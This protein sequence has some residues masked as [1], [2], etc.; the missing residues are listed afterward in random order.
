MLVVV[1]L[2]TGC[3]S[4][5]GAIPVN[6]PADPAV[7]H[8]A[9][10]V[11]RGTVAADHRYFSGIPYA[12][13]PIGQLRF[14]SP[15]PVAAWTGLRDATRPGSRCIQDASN[16]VDRRRTSEDCLTLNVWT[17]PPS[18]EPRPVMVWI[19]GGGFFNG[20]G[21]TYDAR[22]LA[23][24]G[25]IIVV[26]INYRLGALGFLA[27][28]ALGRDGAIGDYGLADQQAALRWVHDNIAD[29][30]GDPG[31]V[32]IAGESAGGV[33]VC[34][35]LIAPGSAGLF[36]AA[37]IQSAPCQTQYD[38]PTAQQTS[39]A[40][41]AELGCADPAAA[42]QCLR[43]LPVEK[44]HHPL[45][46]G[47]IG[48]ERL[49]GPVTGT[50]TLPVNPIVGIAEG[51]GARV[52]VMIGTNANEFTMFAAVQLIRGRPFDTA[53]YLELLTEAFGPNASAVA[54]AYPPD[55]FGGDVALA[56][57]AAVTAGDFACVADFLADAHD[58]EPVFAYE[59]NDPAAPAPE[60][61]REAPFSIGAAHSLE[62]PYLFDDDGAPPLNPAQ[63]RLSD[64]MIGY[65]SRFV[66][67]GEPGADWPEMADRNAG[68]RMSLQPDGN[69]VITTYEQKHECAF[70]AG[71]RR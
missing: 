70:W 32:T 41:A 56:Y 7:V 19:H 54:A 21:A 71:L 30:G 11:L 38:L 57:S 48:S 3:A 26:T 46:Y 1:V 51:K 4:G 60:A 47:R 17:P 55:R 53:H 29:F 65:W 25:G 43:A 35:H 22:R 61:F 9:A 13:P 69:R 58:D 42:A 16:N 27:H 59:F 68:K 28:P 39:M 15:A 49:S 33:S 14:Q 5:G 45:M 31:K 67:T 63:R 44:F 10:G 23:D 6:P 8:I 64:E 36:R 52:P 40:Y 2:L 34:D 62:L 12:A 20:S 37:I 50:P 66:A 18:A 24:Q